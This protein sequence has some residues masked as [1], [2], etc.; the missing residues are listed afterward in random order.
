MRP[1]TAHLGSRLVLAQSLIDDLAQQIVACPGE[2]FDLDDEFFRTKGI[3]A[4]AARR[5]LGVPIRHGVIW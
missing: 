5:T 4:V 3:T 1:R 2:I